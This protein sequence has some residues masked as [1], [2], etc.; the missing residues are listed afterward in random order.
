MM[1]ELV[2]RALCFFLVWPLLVLRYGRP[3]PARPGPRALVSYRR[4]WAAIV[5]MRQRTLYFRLQVA[6][7]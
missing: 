5:P 6:I 7:A 4:Q 1:I 3:S 2:S